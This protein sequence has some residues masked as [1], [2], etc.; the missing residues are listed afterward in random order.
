MVIGKSERI[1]LARRSGIGRMAAACHTDAV[2]PDKR[3]VRRSALAVR[4]EA[5]GTPFKEGGGQV[6]LCCICQ[7]GGNA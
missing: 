3:P 1:G 2:W 7:R 4:S 6:D 5:G